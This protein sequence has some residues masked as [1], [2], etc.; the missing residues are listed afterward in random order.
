MRSVDHT[1]LIAEKYPHGPYKM[2]DPAKFLNEMKESSGSD[3]SAQW[4]KV[5]EFYNKKLWHQLTVL[6]QSIIKEPSLQVAQ[7]IA[8]VA[9]VS[10]K[11]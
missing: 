11:L 10:N 9:R 7:S 5:E 8:M 6:L 1:F 2:P 3:L 4:V